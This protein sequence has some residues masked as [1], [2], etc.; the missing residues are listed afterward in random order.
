MANMAAP[1]PVERRAFDVEEVE[2]LIRTRRSVRLYKKDAVPEDLIRRVI[3]MARW[4]P[5]GANSQPWR[6]VI[7]RD[8]ALIEEIRRVV[9]RWMEITQKVFTRPGPGWKVLKLLWRVL[10]PG[11]FRTIEPRILQG[12]RA[13]LEFRNTDVLL[14]A[15]VLVVILGNRCSSTALEDCSAATQTMALSAHA[16][17][18]GSCWIGFAEK[19]LPY[20]RA[21]KKRLGIGG[22]WFLATVSTLGYPLV[23][24]GRA[25][26]ER[27]EPEVVWVG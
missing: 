21:M 24:Y 11:T 14:R 23:D 12:M 27:D 25:V 6:F 18:L 22:D 2:R 1:A 9:V 5:S 13:L 20:S 4:A 16:L 3:D 17:G 7:V 10:M 26:I 15:P 8:R 19:F